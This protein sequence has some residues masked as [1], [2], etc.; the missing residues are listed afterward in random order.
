MKINSL[1]LPFG[2]YLYR[3]PDD[4]SPEWPYFTTYNAWRYKG[5]YKR[6]LV[7]TIGNWNLRLW[8]IEK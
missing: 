5:I 8:R 1:K 2:L 7:L 3:N 6:Y 4:V